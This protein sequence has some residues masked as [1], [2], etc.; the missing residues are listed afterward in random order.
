MHQDHVPSLPPTFH[1]IGST[2]VCPIQ[3]LVRLVSSDESAEVTAASIQIISLQGHPEF[4][5]S[6]VNK[7]I[8]VREC[9]G[10]ISE[11]LATAS[12]E[13]ADQSSQGIKIGRLFL[14]MLGAV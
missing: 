11:E 4:T 6:I 1:S 3:G 8:E 12:R 5:S 9:G 14:E 2:L 7:V 10:V 13:H